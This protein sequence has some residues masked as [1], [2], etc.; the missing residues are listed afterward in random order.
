MIPPLKGSPRSGV[1]ERGCEIV[2]LEKKWYR[3]INSNLG[4]KQ[5]CIKP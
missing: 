5:L 1:R 4:T 3:I 2:D